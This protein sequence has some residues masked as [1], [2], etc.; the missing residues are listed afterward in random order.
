MDGRDLNIAR[1]FIREWGVYTNINSAYTV[2][3]MTFF[4]LF[5]DLSTA[6]F[7]RPKSTRANFEP[8]YLLGLNFGNPQLKVKL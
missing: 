5:L 8:R 7:A 3:S 6:I 4:V 1:P 2:L